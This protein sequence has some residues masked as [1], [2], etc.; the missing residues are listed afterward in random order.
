MT[1]VFDPEMRQRKEYR[2][3]TPTTVN[4][5]DVETLAMGLELEYCQSAASLRRQGTT[6]TAYVEAGLRDADMLP[7]IPFG[8]DKR[9]SH[10]AAHYPV[11]AGRL[12]K[13]QLEMGECGC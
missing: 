6:L 11:L 9:E 12:A 10:L 2:M 4:E 3:T 13:M 5:T 1:F 8:P 7:G